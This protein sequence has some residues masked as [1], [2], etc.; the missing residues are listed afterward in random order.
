[1]AKHYYE[2]LLTSLDP[3][4]RLLVRQHYNFY[5][6]LELGINSPKTKAQERFVLVCKGLASPSS[7]HE[8]A[9]WEYIQKRDIYLEYIRKQDSISRKKTTKIKTV[10]KEKFAQGTQSNTRKRRLTEETARPYREG[11]C[12]KCEKEIDPKRLDMYPQEKLCV[13]CK[14][15]V[16][17]SSLNN[18]KRKVAA[19]GISGSREAHKKMRKW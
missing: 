12:R 19:D 14:S 15:D 13:Q 18:G 5:R 6:N 4:S 7:D 11:C 9:Y 8:K 3:A 17:K 2:G 1:M 16:E 10:T